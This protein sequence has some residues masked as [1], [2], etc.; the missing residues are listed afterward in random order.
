LFLR[1]NIAISVSLRL[2]NIKPMV[3]QLVGSS[4]SGF[5]TA[6]LGGVQRQLNLIVGKVGCSESGMI[7]AE[8]LNGH[9]DEIA[10]LRTECQRLN[11]CLY[12][13][14]KEDECQL[15]KEK[16]P[17]EREIRGLKADLERSE[18][19]RRHLQNGLRRAQKAADVTH[20][21]SGPTPAAI[22]PSRDL[23]ATSQTCSLD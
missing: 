13:S 23:I 14:D 21:G 20:S 17:L 3:P 2:G 8:A 19:L 7:F 6:E 10:K 1:F 16:D 18:E 11:R 9:E 12:Q 4:G 15:M 22:T 5:T